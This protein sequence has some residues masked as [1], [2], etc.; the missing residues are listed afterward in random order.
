MVE[1]Q[2]LKG[3][4]MK[5]KGRTKFFS[6]LLGI[7]F[8]AMGL[9]AFSQLLFLGRIDDPG[10]DS[11]WKDDKEA[12][13][14]RIGL[15]KPEVL[16]WSPRIIL[17]HKFLSAEECDYLIAIAGPRLAKS[18]VVDT[19]TGKG[20]E[21]KVRTSTGMFL[22]N[23]DRRYPM[24]QAIERR[25]AVYSMIPVENGELLQ[26]LRYEPNQYY[27][28]HHDYFSDQFNLKRGGQRVATVL[29]Y[30]SDVEEGGETI[31][32]SVQC[33][34]LKMLYMYSFLSIFLFPKVGD[35]ECEC[36][37]ELRKGLCVKPR[38]G[39][40]ILF[41]SAALDGNVDSNSLHGGCSVLRGEKWSATKWLRQSR[42]S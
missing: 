42:F 40:A 18:T 22:S 24:I 5:P 34:L 16:N 32:P 37:G 4:A 26:V 36:G 8:V 15:V 3:N 25:I 31:F 20:I 10:S 11:R 23:Y 35:G 17:L 7:L 9:A 1:M 27:K 2:S 14:L 28:P 39:D 38:K 30:L 29:M 33:L 41:W 6:V 12:R 19:S 21:S 13:L